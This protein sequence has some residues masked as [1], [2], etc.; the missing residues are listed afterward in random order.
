MVGFVSKNSGKKLQRKRNFD[1]NKE[2]II[3]Q[4]EL[5]NL[6]YY[7]DSKGKVH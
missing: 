1:P 3:I 5:S 7:F 6:M 2:R 4:P